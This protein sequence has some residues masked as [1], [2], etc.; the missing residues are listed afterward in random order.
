MSAYLSFA[1]AR[2]A[3]VKTQ[4]PDCSNGEISKLLSA[5]WKDAPEEIKQSFREE[6]Q[7]KWAAYKEGMKAMRAKRRKNRVDWAASKSND[8]TEDDFEAVENDFEVQLGLPG[9]ESSGNP[10]PDEMMAAS[11][12]RG[13]RGGPQLTNIGTDS[14]QNYGAWFNGLSGMNSGTGGLGGDPAASSTNGNFN[15]FD[16]ASYPYNQ[17]GN[18]SM[19][20]NSHQALVMAQL[21]GASSHYDPRYPGLLRKLAELN[22]FRFIL[23]NS[24][25]HLFNLRSTSQ[26]RLTYSRT[27]LN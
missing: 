16:T 5:A 20:A 23:E 18:Y 22:T 4:Y 15:Q 2:R 26:R 21:R 12:L 6:E 13:V 17:F 19:G 14:G 7:Q 8:Y 25:W 9:M 1:N 27:S 10:N 11:A 3:A 24:N